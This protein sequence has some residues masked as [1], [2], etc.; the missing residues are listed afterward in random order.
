M[1]VN[2]GGGGIIQKHPN[3]QASACVNSKDMHYRYSFEVLL[4]N[5]SRVNSKKNERF[6]LKS[7]NKFMI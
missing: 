1:S 2:V 5:T 4:D 7:T 6:K 3:T